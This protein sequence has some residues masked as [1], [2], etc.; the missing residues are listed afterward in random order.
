MELGSQGSAAFALGI[1]TTTPATLLRKQPPLQGTGRGAA[2]GQQRPK[3][4]HT[5]ACVCVLVCVCVIP[6]HGQ[7]E[8]LNRIL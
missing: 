2:G 3:H 5:Q 8:S 4:A 6:G 7:G 1:H